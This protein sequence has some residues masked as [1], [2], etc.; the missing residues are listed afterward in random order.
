ML[1]PTLTETTQLKAKCQ[2]ASISLFDYCK[3]VD[4][5]DFYDEEE[6]HYLK[7]MCDAIQEFENDD[8]EA[9][10]INMPPRH[11]KNKNS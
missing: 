8:N 6:A 10:I 9:L 2:L 3:I 11:R 4:S 5:S 1:T 7:E